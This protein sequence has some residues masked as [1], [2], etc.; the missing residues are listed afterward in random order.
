MRSFGSQ[1]LSAWLWSVRQRKARS[2]RE[3]LHGKASQEG[4]SWQGRV[5]H[6]RLCLFCG[7]WFWVRKRIRSAQ[8]ELRWHDICPRCIPLT[9]HPLL[10]A[11]V[12]AAGLDGKERAPAL[13]PTTPT[14]LVS[15][16]RWARS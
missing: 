3:R 15:R 12:R 8:A 6:E 11:F 5:G 10:R 16:T 7:R 2:R 14:A 4:G 13:S 1:R 9:G